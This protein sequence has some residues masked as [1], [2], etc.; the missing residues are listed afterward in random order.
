MA[1][2]PHL[3][4]SGVPKHLIPRGSSRQPRCLEEQD[5]RFYLQWLRE[6]S[7]QK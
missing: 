1:H 3:D 2:H 4:L 6:A 7:V 5:Y